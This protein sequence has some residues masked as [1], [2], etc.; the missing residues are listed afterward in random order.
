V[1]NVGNVPVTNFSFS[2]QVKSGYKRGAAAC[3]YISVRLVTNGEPIII[4][5]S[6]KGCVSELILQNAE[7]KVSGKNVDLSSFGTDPSSWVTV[8]CQS[9]A[10]TIR[11]FVDDHLAFEAPLPSEEMKIVGIGFS[12]QGTGAVR[13]VLLKE[14]DRIALKDF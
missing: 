7:Q 8:S 1:G 14:G 5:L 9:T 13:K 11:Y 4:P 10:K 12:F 6:V 3:Q 2:A